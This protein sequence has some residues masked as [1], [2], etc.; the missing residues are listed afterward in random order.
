MTGTVMSL[1]VNKQLVKIHTDLLL[2]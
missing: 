1:A 2:L